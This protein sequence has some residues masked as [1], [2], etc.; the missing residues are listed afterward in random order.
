MR[1]PLLHFLLLGAL[2]WTL[3][4]HLT[5]SATERHIRISRADIAGIIANYRQQYGS[6]P[7]T[8]QLDALT[9][10]FV[11]EEIYYREAVQQGLDRD[12][13]I[14][15]RRLV[16]KYEF[17]QQDLATIPQPHEAD[18]AAW[19]AAHQGQYRRPARVSFTQIYFSP[20]TR[21]EQAAY[22]NALRERSSLVSSGRTRAPQ[23]GDAFPGTTDFSS[24]T[25]QDVERVFGPGSLSDSIFA[26]PLATW[27]A[28][29]RSGLG[30]HLVRVDAR[31][32]AQTPP[33][34]EVSERVR[35]DWLEAQRERHN[36]DS[37][38]RLKARYTI[39]QPADK[40]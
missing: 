34:S 26:L 30:W 15:R 3:T 31:E 37:Y 40:P 10:A 4:S 28:P 13:E 21:G 27:S 6:Q 12:D 17:L 14:V 32:P 7:S 16:Q 11:R 5:H 36:D 29:L 23:D 2:L 33:Q 38:A 20:D 1:E 19:Y 9:D 8:A 22:D 25:A 18:L 39:E 35:R 24:L